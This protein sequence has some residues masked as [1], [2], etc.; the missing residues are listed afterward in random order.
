MD[1]TKKLRFDSEDIGVYIAGD[2]VYNAPARSYDMVTI[3]GRNGNLAIDRGKYENIEVKYPAFIWADTQADFRTKISNIRG[4]LTSKTGYR[5]L[6]DTYNPDEYRMA[7]YKAGLEVEP[8]YYNRAGEFELVFDCKPQRYLTA[9]DIEITVA[10]GDEITNPTQ[11]EA[12]PL[13]E[14]VG[15]GTL[16]VGNTSVTIT[17]TAT[18]DIFIDCEIMDAYTIEGGAIVSANDKISL[19]EAAFPTLGPGDTGITF[20]GLTS[21]KITPRWWRL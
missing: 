2:S 9:G 1:E 8:V 12:L 20:T 3:P 7:I 5:R 10:S 13:I 18:Q 6:E 15:A 11:F 17:G 4:V 19:N 16:T 14:V 21:V